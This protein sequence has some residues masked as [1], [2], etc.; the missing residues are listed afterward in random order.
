V[1]VKTGESVF[2]ISVGPEALAVGQGLSTTFYL[3]PAKGSTLPE[4]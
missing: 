3:L 1:N 2:G 4:G